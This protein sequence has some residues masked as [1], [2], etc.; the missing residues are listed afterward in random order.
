M[1]QLFTT[2]F[3][4]KVEGDDEGFRNSKGRT[5]DKYGW[6]KTIKDVSEQLNENWDI[7]AKRSVI[8]FLSKLQYLIIEAEERNE[9]MELQRALNGR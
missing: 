2:I 6:F 3:K 7:T 9:E 8:D 5:A 1:H 4:R